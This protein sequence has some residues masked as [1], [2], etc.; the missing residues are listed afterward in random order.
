MTDKY[1]KGELVKIIRPLGKD[2]LIRIPGEIVI[3][4]KKQKI[5]LPKIVPQSELSDK[6]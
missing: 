3:L 6:P 5:F 4:G 2:A 1:Y